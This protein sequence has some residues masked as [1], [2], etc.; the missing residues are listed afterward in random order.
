MDE[1]KVVIA[2]FAFES[3]RK[4][5]DFL[6]NFSKTNAD[7]QVSDLLKHSK[8][9]QT[10]PRKNPLEPSLQQAAVEYRFLLFKNFKIIYTILEDEKIVLLVM[11]F[12]TRQQPGKLKLPF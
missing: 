12:D 8:K 11:V 5:H 6:K 4:T 2:D 7:K 1:Y 9:L 10:L 3:I